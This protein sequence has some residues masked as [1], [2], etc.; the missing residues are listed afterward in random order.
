MT[1]KPADAK[2]HEGLMDHLATLKRKELYWQNEKD[3]YTEVKK[4]R[5]NMYNPKPC[6]VCNGQD[7]F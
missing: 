5:D 7:N 1:H 4:K 3:K 6:S 2:R